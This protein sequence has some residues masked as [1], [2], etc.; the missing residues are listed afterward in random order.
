AAGWCT[1]REQ[2]VRLGA[3]DAEALTEAALGDEGP[4]TGL[5]EQSLAG[6][7]RGRG[8][9]AE[10]AHIPDPIWRPAFE[11]YIATLL[12]IGTTSA[13]HIAQ[14]GSGPRAKNAR[15][16]SSDASGVSGR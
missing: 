10:V 9:V 2:F 6:L 14:N 12:A 11:R 5:L 13:G 15:S 1:D 8:A 3:A 7:R 16:S 4:G